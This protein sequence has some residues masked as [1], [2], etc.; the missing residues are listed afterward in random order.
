MQ[1]KQAQSGWR[2]PD[3]DLEI[4][5]FMLANLDEQQWVTDTQMWAS[6]CS[7]MAC[8]ILCHVC[9]VDSLSPNKNVK[10]ILWLLLSYKERRAEYR[11]G[12]S[13]ACWSWACGPGRGTSTF[14]A[15]LVCQ[16]TAG[17]RTL[18]SRWAGKGEILERVRPCR[19][20]RGL[21]LSFCVRKPIL[22]LTT[23][24]N[25]AFLGCKFRISV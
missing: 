7:L 21:W 12:R 24:V 20:G 10:G 23:T 25:Q 14:R 3:A 18:E 19:P 2:G 1:Q 17:R 22:D 9:K 8:G 16:R 11:L 15:G 13:E 4:E 5:S 6:P